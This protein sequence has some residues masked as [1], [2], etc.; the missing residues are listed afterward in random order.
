MAKIK[1]KIRYRERK[2][3]LAFNG[4]NVCAYG[5]HFHIIL[6]KKLICTESRR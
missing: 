5:S 4:K 2:F 1:A 3:C 6:E